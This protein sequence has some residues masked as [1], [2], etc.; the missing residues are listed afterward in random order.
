MSTL[1]ENHITGDDTA[2]A[3]SMTSGDAQTFTPSASHTIASVKLKLY[4]GNA[5]NPPGIITVSIRGVDGG[6]G[7]PT[8][9]DLCLG[10]TDGDTL[11]QTTTGEW[12]EITFGAGTNLTATTPY[13]IYAWSA[14]IAAFWRVDEDNGYAGGK[15]CTTAD[16]GST[17]LDIGGG[18]HDLMF[19]E[20]GELS[21]YPIVYTQAC[22]NTTAIKSIGHGRGDSEG[23]ASITQHGHCWNTSTNPTTSNSKTENGAKPNL[24]QFQS[25]ITGLTP[26]TLYYVRAYATN[27]SGT[28]YGVNVEITTGTTIGRREWWVDTDGAFHWFTPWGTHVKMDGT[29]DD[30][31]L[32]WWYGHRF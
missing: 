16:G 28:G 29:A 27:S 13:A 15:Q 3:I 24:G 32:P 20:W 25:F 7:L 19:E 18:L 12:R 21:D 30:G 6:T 31:G 2:Y 5:S 9:N 4:R 23:G 17:W 1:Y 10:T 26:G 14:A 8:G 11:T 22:T